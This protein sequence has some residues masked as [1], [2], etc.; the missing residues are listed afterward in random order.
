MS[1]IL[2]CDA[3][4]NSDEWLVSRLGVVT[5]SCASLARA[6]SNGLTAQQQAYV[7]AVRAGVPDPVGLAGYK[8]APTS[9][10]VQLAIAG[11]KLPEVWSDGALTYARDLARERLGG[12]APQGGSQG[13]A[14]RIGHEQEPQAVAEYEAVTGEF[15]KAVGF[16]YTPDRRFGASPDRVVVGEPGALEV[17]TMVSTATLW[18]ACVEGDVSDFRDQA[19]MQMWL[20]RLQ[21]VDL[22]LWIPEMRILKVVRI[23]RDESELEA[24]ETDLI[25]FDRLVEQQRSRMAVALGLDPATGRV[26]YPDGLEDMPAPAPTTEPAAPARVLAAADF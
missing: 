23:E 3:E 13:F 7:N 10:L 24:L 1:G 25:A 14:A 9:E 16:A 20:L 18:T 8:K 17:K 21:W 6:R 26:E 15:T 4:Q 2:W 12:G 19:L 11:H 22:C 5:A